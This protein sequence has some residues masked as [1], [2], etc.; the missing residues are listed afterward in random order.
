MYFYSCKIGYTLYSSIKIILIL[1]MNFTHMKNTIS[2]DLKN[3]L[4]MLGSKWTLLI[5]QELMGS[6]K[7]F[8]E[9]QRDCEVCPR[10]LSTRLD[11]LE[12]I[13]IVTKKVYSQTPPKVEYSLTTK[14][15]SLSSV[16]NAIADWSKSN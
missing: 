15:R 14:G 3:S 6:N 13:G 4:E 9:I 16:I 5:V 10:T 7:R 2:S 11:E 8:N 12:K 1:L